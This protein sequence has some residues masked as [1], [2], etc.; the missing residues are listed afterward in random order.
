M[1]TAERY[2]GAHGFT[3]LEVILAM[4]IVLVGFIGVLGALPVGIDSAESVILQDSAINLIHS[5]FAEFR[6]D[7]L[8]PGTDLLEGSGYMT[9]KQE[10]LNGESGGNWHD[11]ASKA[12]DPYENFEDIT[13]FAWKVDV[14]ALNNDANTPSITS[15]AAVP[16]MFKVTVTVHTKGSK[17]EFRFTQYMFSYD[18]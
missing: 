2:N 15:G 1:A 4:F 5:K 8:N 12:G 13:R 18:G 3:L 11:F 9:S 7:R 14:A 17:K 10:P 16:G 6:R